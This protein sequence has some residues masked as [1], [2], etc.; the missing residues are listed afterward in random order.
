MS[1]LDYLFKKKEEVNV[2][3]TD[4]VINA[5]TDVQF[6]R[7]VNRLYTQMLAIEQ[8]DM[9]KEVIDELQARQKCVAQFGHAIPNNIEEA[10]SLL[11][12]LNGNNA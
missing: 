8:G 6:K 7:N 2:A 10:K 5:T 11:E 12:K 9:R 3:A 4:V 1:I